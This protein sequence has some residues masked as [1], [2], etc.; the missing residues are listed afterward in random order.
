MGVSLCGVGVKGSASWL[1]RLLSCLPPAAAWPLL[2]DFML[3]LTFSS[4][5]VAAACG[6]L[7]VLRHISCLPASLPAGLASQSQLGAGLA[8]GSPLPALHS[9][10]A[11]LHRTALGLTALLYRRHCTT[12]PQAYFILDELLLAGEL[13]ETSKKAVGRVIEAQDQLVEQ[14]KAGNAPESFANFSGPRG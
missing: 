1:V 5:K 7:T 13:Q 3:P 4:Y 10:S 14:V 2:P 9:H 11:T 12:V 8:V 6:V